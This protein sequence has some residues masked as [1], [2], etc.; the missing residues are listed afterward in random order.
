MAVALDMQ[1]NPEKAAQHYRRALELNPERAEIRVLFGSLLERAGDPV[2]AEARYREAL[3]L[4]PGNSGAREGVCRLQERAGLA[5]APPLF[6][7]CGGERW[8]DH[9]TNAPPTLTV[10]E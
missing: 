3:A 5:F 9:L 2:G 4:Q 1:D 6:P 10:E 7:A 8:W